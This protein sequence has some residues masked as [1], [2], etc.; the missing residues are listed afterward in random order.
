MT[1][2]PTCGAAVRVARV[3]GDPQLVSFDAHEASYGPNRYVER[4]G[5]MHP[6]RPSWTGAAFRRHDCTDPVGRRAA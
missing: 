4:S 1:A 3:A 2:C 5:L 6:V